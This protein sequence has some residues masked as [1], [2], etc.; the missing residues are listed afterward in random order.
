MEKILLVDDEQHVLSAL[1]RVLNKHFDV[2]IASTGQQALDILKTT[3]VA[4]V[5]SDYM[6]PHMLGVEL[7]SKV[8]AIWPDTVRIIISGYADYDNV[9]DAIETGVVHRFLAKP[10]DNDA[11]IKHL[12]SAIAEQ[13]SDSKQ[14]DSSP[15]SFSNEELY[16][17]NLLDAILSHIGH[18]I[19]TVSPQ[20]LVSSVNSAA[21]QMFGYSQNEATNLSFVSFLPNYYRRTYAELLAAFHEQ[22]SVGQVT[23]RLIGLKRSGEVFPIELRVSAYRTDVGQQVLCMV[24]DLSEQVKAHSENKQYLDALESCQEGFALFSP[25]GR[26]LRCNHQFKQIYKG[27][28]QGP[29]EGIKY[30]EFLLDCIESGLFPAAHENPKAWVEQFMADRLSLEFNQ[31]YE[32]EPGRWIKVSE[33][34]T[35]HD[36][37]ISFHLDVTEQKNTEL[38]LLNALNEVNAASNAR[39][40]FFAMM[41]HELRTPLNG[42]LGLLDVL[43][44]TP[45][46]GQQLK[47]VTTA[48]VSGKALLAIISDIL[49]FSK[50]EVQKLELKPTECHLK[51]LINEIAALFNPRIEEKS[52]SL[53]LDIDPSLPDVVLV[54]AY[55]LKQVLLNLVSNAVKFTHKGSIVISIKADEAEQLVFKVVD[56]GVGIPEAEKPKIFSEFC[57]IQ[58][59]DAPAQYEG[60]GLGLAIS[61]SL[62][63]LLG[64]EL[65]FVSEEGVGTEFW[66]TLSLPVVASASVS[67]SSMTPKQQD[68]LQGR[69]LI[70]DDSET[71]RLVARA[72]LETFGIDVSSAESGECAIELCKDTSFDVVLMDISMPGLDGI[73]TTHIVRTF[74]HMQSVPIVALT[75]YGLPEDKAYFLE[76]GMSDYLEKPIDKQKL[77]ELLAPYLQGGSVPYRSHHITS[78][79]LFDENRLMQLGED[80]SLELLPKLVSV[81][82]QDAQTRIAELST[83]SANRS[84]MTVVTRHLHTL[85]SSSALYGLEYFH[86]EARRLER[87]SKDAPEEVLQALPRFIEMANASL[88]LLAGYMGDTNLSS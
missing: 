79:Q 40:R 84:D 39:S 38:S 86:Q 57:T 46:T 56:S 28:R 21:E 36:R 16:S 70:V 3:S 63:R 88:V 29:K 1:R 74:P 22:G 5:V 76:Q 26:L 61:H 8:E 17:S 68:K 73:E 65:C 30:D 58:N 64:G 14:L 87:L 80:T 77:R 42:V 51:R 60:T 12:T 31:E 45:L 15:L 19:F 25:G 27:C 32:V 33:T 83:A 55:R 66:F 54:D 23:K 75:A 48:S 2:L 18:A 7:L 20:G 62:V 59:Q 52:I 81:F 13:Q 43:K 53:D 71:N 69:V 78:E 37:V 47:Y 35:E 85:G 10:W 82:M 9:M 11:L 24:D 67:E 6:M 4:A 34:T 50:L 44:D 41:S 72:M 49:D